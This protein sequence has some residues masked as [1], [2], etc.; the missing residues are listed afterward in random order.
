MADLDPVWEVSVEEVKAMLD[1]KQAF[2]LLDVREPDEHATARI[3]GAEL[4]P[5]G[6][7]PAVLPRLQEH[8]DK[9]VIAHCHMGGRSLKAAVFL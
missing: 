5:L 1:S 7:L 4:V 2:L 9:P 6:D 3:P 8:A